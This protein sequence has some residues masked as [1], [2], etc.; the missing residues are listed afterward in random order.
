MQDGSEIDE[1]KLDVLDLADAVESAERVF[2]PRFYSRT[3]PPGYSL[4]FFIR[5][6][7]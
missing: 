7:Q 2:L 3:I 5:L 4:R 6:C 1:W